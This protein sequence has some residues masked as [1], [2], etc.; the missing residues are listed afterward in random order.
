[1]SKEDRQP[2]SHNALT[3]CIVSL[4]L[5]CVFR[6]QVSTAL[7]AAPKNDEPVARSASAITLDYDGAL[8]IWMPLEM[9][10][11]AQADVEELQIARQEIRLI[12][13]R[14]QLKDERIALLLH[15]SADS[16]KI[17]E[18]VTGVLDKAVAAQREAEEDEDGLFS[19]QPIIWLLGGI[20]V[21]AVGM[22]LIVNFK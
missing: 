8:G 10:K 1:M 9:A 11:K 15:A 21:G 22:A 7:A 4:A 13:E 18:T 17:A 16:K 14:L 19:G 20:I 2:K 6:L 5:L 12:D 3:S